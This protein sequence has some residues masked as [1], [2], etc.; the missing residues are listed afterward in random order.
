MPDDEIE[1]RLT[2]TDDGRLFFSRYNYGKG[3]NTL[4][5][6]NAELSSTM[7]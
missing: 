5:L 3:E 2:L 4:S 1:Q 7:K 6:L